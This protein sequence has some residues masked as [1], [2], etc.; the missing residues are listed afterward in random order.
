[1]TELT[2]FELDCAILAAAVYLVLVRP[3][4]VGS[5]VPNYHAEWLLWFFLA[6]VVTLLRLICPPSG[7]ICFF[8]QVRSLVSV[9]VSG[10]R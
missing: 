4:Q 6:M 9:R 2:K 5:E 10:D 7:K 8:I 1:M 3:Q